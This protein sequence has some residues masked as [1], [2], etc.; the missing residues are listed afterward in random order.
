MQV[1]ASSTTNAHKDL[2]LS[3][4]CSLS[5]RAHGEIDKLSPETCEK[6]R[7][8]LWWSKGVYGYH[9]RPPPSPR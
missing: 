1:T 6:G 2:R 4:L 8:N 7:L 5:R 9:I 3:Y